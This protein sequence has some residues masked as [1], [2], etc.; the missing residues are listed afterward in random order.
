M[1]RRW[2]KT[3]AML[4]A[5]VTV[6]TSAKT[7]VMAQEIDTQKQE[8]DVVIQTDIVE[9]QLCEVGWDGETTQS[10][11][12]IE[13]Y[14]VTFNLTGYWEGG[15]NASIRI[16]NLSNS[17]IENWTIEVAY[18]G[19]ISNIWNAVVVSQEE[20]KYVLKNAQWNQ[21]ELKQLINFIILWII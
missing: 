8:E 13:N 11:Y 7:G 1:K 5:M 10:I 20:G 4:L 14:K 9:E 21:M 18:D 3:V 19:S 2:T 15:Y 6:V 17:L 12:E 16:D